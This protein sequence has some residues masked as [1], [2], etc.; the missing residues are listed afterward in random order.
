MFH[1]KH[2]RHGRLQVLA[3][4]FLS[5]ERD[6]YHFVVSYQGDKLASDPLVDDARMKTS[7]DF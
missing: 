4:Y 7:L 5:E 2:K 6:S 3:T 1:L